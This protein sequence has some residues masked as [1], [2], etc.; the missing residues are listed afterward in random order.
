MN[1][2]LQIRIEVILLIFCTT[3]TITWANQTKIYIIPDNVERQ[4][5]MEYTSQETCYSLLHVLTQS[6]Q[7]FM[8]NTTIT[9]LP[10]QYLVNESFGNIIIE[11]IEHFAMIGA[12]GKNGIIIHCTEHGTM[13][14]YFLSVTN[15]SL[16]S[17]RISHCRGD[18][19]NN[20]IM[21][22][23]ILKYDFDYGQFNFHQNGKYTLVFF[24]TSSITMTR[25]VVEHTDGI[26][27]LAIGV[28]KTLQLI[29]SNFTYNKVNCMIL[30]TENTENVSH[31][32][33]RR[34]H[35]RVL[36]EV[37]NS[38]FAFGNMSSSKLASGISIVL[39]NQ[40]K[41]AAKV[42]LSKVTLKDNRAIMGNLMLAIANCY[43]LNDSVS[44]P[45][46]LIV[47]YD[48]SSV[49]TNDS[50][51]GLVLTSWSRVCDIYSKQNTAFVIQ[52]GR[53][54]KSCVQ[55][56]F[57]MDY[58]SLENIAIE[59]TYMCD[60]A[61]SLMPKEDT[62]FEQVEAGRLSKYVY[63][64]RNLIINNS[65]G[66]RS[67]VSIFHSAI[68]LQ[69]NNTFSSNSGT[70]FIRS[71]EITLR[72]NMAFINNTSNGTILYAEDTTLNN[73]GNIS[74]KQNTGGQ[75]GGITLIR[76]KL[77]DDIN[78]ELQFIANRGYSGG[79][80][81][82]YDSSHIGLFGTIIFKSNFAHYGGAIYVDDA[83]YQNRVRAK[84][85]V[86]CFIEKGSFSTIVFT[87]NTAILSGSTLYG[88]WLDFC[89]ET[90][91]LIESIK[92]ATHCNSAPDIQINNTPTQL[93]AISSNPSRVCICVNSIPHCNVTG[94]KIQK[95]LFPGQ[96]FHIQAVVVGQ[97]F[98]TVPSTVLAEFVN[99][100]VN[101][102]KVQR[103]QNVGRDCTTLDYT[104][105]SANSKETLL[106]S[107]K[108]DYIPEPDFKIF[109]NRPYYDL[110]LLVFRQ[111]S[112]SLQI[113]KCP[114]GYTLLNTTTICVCQDTLTKNG[115]ECYLANQTVIRRNQMWI[116]A[117]FIHTD[118]TI[119]NPGVIVHH[120]CPFDYCENV[121]Q[122]YLDLQCPDD[123]C[124]SGRTG[125][126]CG[127]CPQNFSQVF[128][129]SKCK[130]CS[131][132]WTL[133]ILPLFILA[134]IGLVALLVTLDLTVSIG[135][136]NGLIFYAHIVRAN[137]A[138]FFPPQMTNTFLSWFIAWLN[139]DLGIEMCFFDGLDAYT[140][141]WLQFIFPIYI[142]MLVIVIIVSSHYYTFAARLSGSNAV[143]VLATLFL[144]SYAKLL[145]ITIT[146][147]S[148][149]TLVYPDGHQK[150]VW[151]YDGNVDYI[152]GK[153]IPLFIAALMLLTFLSIPYTLVL[154]CIQWTRL[155]P[156]Y[157]ILF[158]VRK[159]MPLFDAY[160]GVYRRQHGYWTGLLLLVRVG[161]FL[162]FAVNVLGNPSVNLL[163]VA[164]T[165][166]CLITYLAI[167][168]RV[169]RQRYL[170][171]IENSFLLNLGVVSAVTPSTRLFEYTQEVVIKTS[172]GIALSTFILII[173]YHA[174]R[175][176]KSTHKGGIFFEYLNTKF[177]SPLLG[178]LK[179][180]QE[181]LSANTTTTTKCNM[182]EPTHSVIELREPLLDCTLNVLEHVQN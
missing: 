123:Q 111:L 17:I 18:T 48:L 10:G 148:S 158:W 6:E 85:M 39:S 49:N 13:S 147:L 32:I 44:Y 24:N 132:V 42:L 101:L 14:F 153:H 65:C 179:S 118:S 68:I 7:F 155:L 36:I 175:R 112:I 141:T 52:G 98:G 163:A 50:S 180:R 157:R 113:S 151:L 95:P 103:A 88:G 140:K 86:N 134:G 146:V 109:A 63:I 128:G 170:S 169:Y 9:L 110:Q 93:S 122:Q 70:V 116:N 31:T 137:H 145:R 46:T 150:R 156:S 144:M 104:V 143:Q 149:T 27:L 37:T 1:K 41:I 26:G 74:F 162:V 160:T 5:C 138:S 164:S 107:V 59:E 80:I 16:S 64:I 30:I 69:G 61:L 19:L 23:I 174:Y 121:N 72:D 11:G 38:S 97:R 15:V 43:R 21:Q 136:I 100:S 165:T 94:Y 181:L 55:L 182:S 3:P 73:Y 51:Q 154:F 28:S 92:C 79:A 127:E 45:Q 99:T 56:H 176:L 119:G 60:Y 76:S 135:T 129:S 12:E 40:R 108:K 83:G 33:T 105:K 131:N 82:M 133:L 87:N 77:Q 171:F 106:L 29:T 20:R 114:L 96:S 53:F 22:L 173:I 124:A 125:I 2:S 115:I 84:Q 58:L 172:V 4:A 161:L 178:K 159:F 47:I 130:E 66:S 35:E 167:F 57:N 34:N 81:A 90:I 117:T 120:N 91:R 89:T 102:D 54:T 126:L 168:E 71:S 142:W 8:S 78:S 75:C 177:I 152:K 62:Y 25:M 139:L 166:F 67:L